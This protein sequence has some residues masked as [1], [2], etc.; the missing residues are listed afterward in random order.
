MEVKIVEIGDN[1][2]KM[3][4]KGEDHTY[5]NLLQYYLAEDKDVVIAKYNIPHPLV[6]E[7]ELYV[8]TNGTNPLEVIKRANERIIE[9]CQ[10]LLNQI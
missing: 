8:R 2:V 6:G 10:S 5:L 7:P 3:I 4:I 1:F 9:V